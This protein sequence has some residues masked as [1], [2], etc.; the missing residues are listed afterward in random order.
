MMKKTVFILFAALLAASLASSAAAPAP[1]EKAFPQAAAISSP[2]IQASQI[3][4]TAQ[5]TETPF[6]SPG[7]VPLPSSGPEPS[8]LAIETPVPGKA[9]I[10][11]T[12]DDGPLSDYLLAYPILKEYDIKGTSYIITKFTDAETAGKLNW[13]Q[14][15]EMAEYG[16]VFGAHTRRHNNLTRLSGKK[17]KE[18]CEA[19]GES[20]TAQGFAVPEIMAYPYGSYNKKVIEAIKPYYKQA[21]LAYYR[22]DFVN[23]SGD[24]YKIA[25]ISADMR[26]NS[27]L[28]KLEKL[29]DKA[30]EKGAIIVFRAHTLYKDKPYDTVK[31]NT[32]ILSGCAPQTDSKLF[33]K[34]VQYCVDKGCGFMTMTELMEYME[35][36]AE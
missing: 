13:E 20:F 18:D 12:F 2:S 25:C 3:S 11:F 8:P 28:K 26:T 22:T 35:G 16:W 15:K 36:Q 32:H 17:I 9:V 21:R 4:P 34:L 31:R 29:V 5:P 1:K 23:V 33:N 6:E 10:I 27:S 19:V 30:C 7:P 24:P 14:I